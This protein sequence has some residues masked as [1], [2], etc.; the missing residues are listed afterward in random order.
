MELIEEQ[1]QF[2]RHEVHKRVVVPLWLAWDFDR[3]R[4]PFRIKENVFVQDISGL[5]NDD[6]FSQGQ[7]DSLGGRERERLI[8]HPYGLVA[9]YFGDSAICGTRIDSQI[10][11]LVREIMAYL[12]LV[13]PTPRAG[14][15]VQGAVRDDGSLDV[16][17][18]TLEQQQAIDRVDS[19]NRLRTSDLEI[20]Q[21]L[22]PALHHGMQGE[23]WKFR[24]AFEFHEAAYV[25]G[26]PYWKAGFASKMSSIE[27]L[28]TSMKCQGKKVAHSRILAFLGGDSPIYSGDEELFH[29]NEPSVPKV[30]IA[31]C[32]EDLYRLRNCVAHGDRI[33]K[34]FFDTKLA[35]G[36]DMHI[37]KLDFLS[38]AATSI[39]RQGIIRIAREGLFDHFRDNDSADD[40]FERLLPD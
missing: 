17:S 12:R 31:E 13:R 16:T 30:T 7:L 32:L 37:T 10:Q 38:E 3:K 39:S 20:L 9:H 25:V 23:Y 22:V 8:G 1:G 14:V 24:M 34:E 26:L 18:F 40:F 4:L 11:K 6:S 19:S 28:Y 5:L 15:Y 33:P 35:R 29:D 2:Q 21:E 27:A 36:Y